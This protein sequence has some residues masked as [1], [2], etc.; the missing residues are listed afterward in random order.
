MSTNKGFNLQLSKEVIT[1]AQS[2]DHLALQTIYETYGEA[3]Y[4]LAFRICGNKL[5]SQDIV[6]ESFIL[7]I[8]KINQFNH[9]GSFS[10]WVRKITANE[11]INRIRSETKLYLIDDYETESIASTDLFGIAWLDASLD[12]NKLLNQLTNTQRAVLILHELDGFTH[13]EIALMFSKSE[14]FS[15]T[16]LSRAYIQLKELALKTNVNQGVANA[17]I[18]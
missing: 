13:K 2:G 18:R 1:Q 10:G 16:N 6:Q 14:S 4:N 8:N 17:F 7:L 9:I 5:L 3:C 15:K 11:T 12:L